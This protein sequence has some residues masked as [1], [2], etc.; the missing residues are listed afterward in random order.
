MVARPFLGGASTGIDLLLAGYAAAA[1]LGCFGV[2]FV[3]A[4]KP[5]KTKKLDP[6]YLKV[7]LLSLLLVHWV[8]INGFFLSGARVLLSFNHEKGFAKESN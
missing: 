3:K 8:M 2:M 7:A 4:Y 1:I 6:I 5:P